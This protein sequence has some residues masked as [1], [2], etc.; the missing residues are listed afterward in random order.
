MRERLTMIGTAGLALADGDCKA[1]KLTVSNRFRCAKAETS[2]FLLNG[3]SVLPE[4]AFGSD[5][6][7]NDSSSLLLRLGTPGASTLPNV[8]KPGPN[9]IGP[10]VVGDIKLVDLEYENGNTSRGKALSRRP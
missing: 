3:L 10:G 7:T 4:S 6:G 9:G 2:R 1:K 8:G 5:G